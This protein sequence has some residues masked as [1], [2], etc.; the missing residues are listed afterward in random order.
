MKYLDSLEKFDK[1][2]IEHQLQ[3]INFLGYK[4]FPLIRKNLINTYLQNEGGVVSS[5]HKK[6]KVSD[7]I[8]IF[9]GVKKSIVSLSRLLISNSN[10]KRFLFLGFSRRTLVDSI[11]YVDKFHDPIIDSLNHEDCLMLERPFKFS[12]C[13]NRKTNCDITDYDFVVYLSS[14]IAKL[15]TPFYLLF[16]WRNVSSTVHNI[17]LA[18]DG[19]LISKFSFVNIIINFLC[20]KWFA[21]IVL[22]KV[23]PDKLILTSRWLHYPFIYAARSKGIKVIELQHGSILRQNVFYREFDEGDLYADQMFTFGKYWNDRKWNTAE[24]TAVGSGY[25]KFD[26]VTSSKA[27]VINTVIVISQPEMQNKLI[28]DMSLLASNNE[29]LKFLIKLHPQDV[30]N[31]MTRYAKLF[32]YKNISFLSDSKVDI[33]SIL[34]RYS[35]VIGYNST[36]LFEAYHLGLSVG[37]FCSDGLSEADYEQYFGTGNQ[38]FHKIYVN[39][40]VLNLFFE[41]IESDTITFYDELDR[42]LIRKCLYEESF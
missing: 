37:L 14:F 23:R 41:R 42:K 4:V 26:K 28:A 6:Y 10:C 30:D 25:C 11:G 16:F 9:S 27:T 17:N 38:L 33:N 2:I 35:L 13:M 12:H 1:I 21:K 39:E 31:Y 5:N 24:V 8:L 40:P 3:K 15:L 32:K 29:N 36:V 22:D 19:Q 34:S 7:L 20:E 18:L